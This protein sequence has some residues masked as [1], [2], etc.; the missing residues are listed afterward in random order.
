LDHKAGRV[1]A[2]RFMIPRYIKSGCGKLGIGSGR[3]AG[4]L[5]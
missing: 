5:F 1:F 4:F 3:I 2:V